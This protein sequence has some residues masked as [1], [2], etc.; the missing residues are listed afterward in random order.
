MKNEYTPVWMTYLFS[1]YTDM[2]PLDKTGFSALEVLKR[3]APHNFARLFI[4]DTKDNLAAPFISQCSTVFDE[5]PKVK[6]VPCFLK[7]QMFIFL[8]LH[9]ALQLLR[10]SFHTLSSKLNSVM[11]SPLLL[12]FSSPLR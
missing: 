1:V 2:Q 7:L 8:A 11:P 9:P 12:L 6:V 5:C 3:S 10:R 4:S